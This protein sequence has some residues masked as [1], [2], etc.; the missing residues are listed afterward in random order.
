[1]GDSE[2]SAASGAMWAVVTLLIV[3]LVV[4]MLYFGGM[5]TRK[6]EIDIEI[7]TPGSGIILPV[8]VSGR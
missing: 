4:A 8:V 6:K 5:F 1:M 3:L 7:K 2:Q